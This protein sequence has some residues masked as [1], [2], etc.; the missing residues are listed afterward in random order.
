MR[1]LQRY[2]RK[3]RTRALKTWTP[4]FILDPG[5]ITAAL[6]GGER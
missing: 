1:R 3:S 4:L 2:R 5:D 6:R